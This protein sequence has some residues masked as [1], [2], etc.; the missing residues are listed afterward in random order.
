MNKSYDSYISVSKLSR[1]AKLFLKNNEEVLFVKKHGT[2][3]TVAGTAGLKN[4]SYS[5]INI[6]K[7][8]DYY[9]DYYLNAG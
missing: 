9:C 8:S 3:L 7:T 6:D 5:Q 1:G 2:M 4:V